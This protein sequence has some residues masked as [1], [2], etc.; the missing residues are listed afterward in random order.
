MRSS[1]TGPINKQI[2][3]TTTGVEPNIKF[4]RNTLYTLPTE[5]HE[6]G[7]FYGQL[8][9]EALKQITDM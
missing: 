3:Q 9:T 4:N 2:R 6:E 8:T 7:S 1:C 5:T